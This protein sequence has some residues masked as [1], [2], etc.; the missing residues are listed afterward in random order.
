M[1]NPAYK[2]AMQELQRDGLIRTYGVSSTTAV[3]LE[4]SENV[5]E[6]GDYSSIELEMNLVF[7]E[8]REKVLPAAEKLGVGII[9]RVPLASGL[10]SGRYTRETRFPENDF[11]N[12]NPEKARSGIRPERLDRAFD[13]LESLKELA[14]AEG[15]DLVQ[16]ALAWLLSHDEVS[17]VIPGCKNAAQVESNVSAGEVRLSS[18]TLTQALA[19]S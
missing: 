12:Y 5:L 7:P 6:V 18:G 15:I 11:R 4:Q 9:V 2:Q 16:L 14:K 17:T 19:T 3:M 1:L 13:R 8:A 10:L